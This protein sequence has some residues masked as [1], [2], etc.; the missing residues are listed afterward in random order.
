VIPASYNGKP[1]TEI[2]GFAFQNQNSITSVTIP[3]SVTKIGQSAF[4]GCGNLTSITIPDSVTVIEQMAFRYCSGLTSVIIGSGILSIRTYAFDDCVNLTSVTFSPRNMAI[5]LDANAFRN[6]GDIRAKFFEGAPSNGVSG[7]YTRPSRGQVWTRQA[8]AQPAVQQ[9]AGTPGLGFSAIN[10]GNA[11]EVDFGTVT[12]GAVVIPATYNG[13]PVTV[14]T[15]DAFA[16][17][18]GITS[19]TIPSSITSIGNTAFNGC[20]SLTSITI[21]AGVTSIGTFAFSGWTASQ[22]ITVRG[23]ANEAAADTAWGASWRR[24]CNARI[25]Y[26]AN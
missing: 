17:Q 13:K 22:T 15:R 19:V 14:I 1:V 6:L 12:S 11:Y 16:Y 7:T 5:S 26:Q 2:E 20:T 9:Q 25:V 24:N 23:K 21:P 3:N 8:A 4:E 10:N 18:S